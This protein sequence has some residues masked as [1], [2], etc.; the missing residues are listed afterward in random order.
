MAYSFNTGQDC[1]IDLQDSNGTTYSFS[2]V[3]GDLLH[4]EADF[5]TDMIRRRPISGGGLSKRR[6]DYKGCKGTLEIGRINSAFEQLFI[7]AQSGY[8]SG[9]DPIT[10]TIFQ[11]VQNRDGTGT[12]SAFQYM[13]CTLW[14]SKGAGYTMGEDSKF[15]LEFEGD[16]I[17]QTQ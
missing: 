7:A 1:T 12:Q 3:G 14:M 9:Q 8:R 15:S 5:D 11:T 13:N 6:I 16:D 2:T 10:Y 4:F 17:V